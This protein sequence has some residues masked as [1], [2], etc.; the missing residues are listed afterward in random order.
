[1]VKGTD[2]LTKYQIDQL[3]K[4]VNDLT[5]EVQLLREANISNDTK[6]KIFSGLNLLAIAVVAAISRVFK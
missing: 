5:T 1:M 6:I 4:A 3:T 2:E